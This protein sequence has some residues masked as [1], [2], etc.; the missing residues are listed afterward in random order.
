MKNAINISN[1]SGGF[2]NSTN[3][4]DLSDIEFAEMLNLNNEIPGKLQPYGKHVNDSKCDAAISIDNVIYGSG[5]YHFNLDRTL[6]GPGTI[7]NT[8]YIAVNDPTNKTVKFINY[9]G[10]SSGS[11][12]ISAKTAVYG[13]SSTTQKVCVYAQDGDIRVVPHPG[14]TGT[15]KVMHYLQGI[16]DFGNTGTT[17]LAIS[18]NAYNS[19]DLFIAG[20]TGKVGS[21]ATTNNLDPERLYKKGEVFKPNYKSELFMESNLT[22]ANIFDESGNTVD[23]SYDRSRADH[24]SLFGANTDYGAGL[25]DDKGSMAVIAYWGKKGN[26][27]DQD[28]TSEAVIYPASQKKVY[29]LW[30][31]C[32]YKNSESPALFLGDIA[33]QDVTG[34]NERK[35]F[36]Y[37]G[38]YGRVPSTNQRITGYKFYWGLIENYDTSANDYASG[39]VT[40]KFLL[41]EVD[42]IQGIRWAGKDTYDNFTEELTS[43]SGGNFYNY[44]YPVGAYANAS[45]FV[46]KQIGK[47]SLEEPY[48]VDKR[49]L[50]GP[51]NTG[52]K[53]VAIANRRAYIGNVKYYDS[54]GN[55]V[56]KNDRILK[57]KINE[58]DYFEEDGFID[59]E[60]EDGDDIISLQTVGPKLLEFKTQKL[61]IINTSRRLEFLEGVFEYKGA[62]FENHITKGEGFVTWFNEHGLYVYDGQRIHDLVIGKNGQPLIDD[63][64]TTIYNDDSVIGYMP[65]TKEIIILAKDNVVLKYDLKSESFTRSTTQMQTVDITNTIN[66]NDGTLSYFYQESGS[67][68]VMKMQNWSNTPQSITYGSKTTLLKTKEWDFTNPA[69]RKNIYTIYINYKAGDNVFVGGYATKYN[70]SPVEGSLTD[71]NQTLASPGANW[72]GTELT[73]T[74]N[75]FK[76]EKIKVSSSNFKN[77]LSFGLIFYG[78]GAV[79]NNFVLNDIQIVFRGKVLK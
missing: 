67:P 21:A 52:F 73:N 36:L 78:N 37:F 28:D 12:S 74:S 2:N 43:S 56:E 42:F 24:H 33:Q 3:V 70:A 50:I 62:N 15:P 72:A 7:S 69:A 77:V 47:L 17:N 38:L 41:A 49:S 26:A 68:D 35:R 63:F 55:L 4:R 5:A 75:E 79:S 65:K 58:F 29:G 46:G 16:R 32:L 23:D 51:A 19:D 8:E 40:N 22:S 20:L 54:Q 59:V 9:T 61:Y 27:T 64:K 57:S 10:T 14:S 39:S 66:T 60:V 1:F 18:L 44:I 31:S 13:G 45:Y 6:D 11:N 76:T 48:L 71:V 25:S 34:N 53:T 30:A